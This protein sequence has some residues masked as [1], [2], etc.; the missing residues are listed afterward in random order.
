MN[1]QF[2]KYYR[3]E[4]YS[5]WYKKTDTYH[6]FRH[7]L[8]RANFEMAQWGEVEVKRG[9]FI[10][11][12]ASLREETGLSERKVRTALKRLKST[13]DLTCES[14]NR[15]TLITV[16]KYDR[17]QGIY[18]DDEVNRRQHDRQAK[19]KQTSLSNNIKN[20]KKI[21]ESVF[22]PPSLSEVEKFFIDNGY[23]DEVARRAYDGYSVAGW[24][25]SRG[26]QIISWRQKMI[27]VWFKSEN[28]NTKVSHGEC[29]LFEVY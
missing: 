13:N 9:Q 1:G 27:H 23:S 22:T 26:K 19:D 16:C 12:I 24:K 2:I 15:Y 20:K 4:M 21:E 18:N 25:D 17:L 11:S 14:T 6:L 3:S 10:T 5:P 7:C 28:L 8:L 29:E